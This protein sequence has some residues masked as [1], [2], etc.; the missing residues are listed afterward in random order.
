MSRV[1]EDYLK[2]VL[3]FVA[4]GVVTAAVGTLIFVIHNIVGSLPN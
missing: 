1:V 3:A 2:G 4:V